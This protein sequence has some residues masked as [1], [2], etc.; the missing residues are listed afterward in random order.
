MR[1]FDHA[2]LVKAARL[3]YAQPHRGYHNQKHLD[4]LMALARRQ[5][6]CRL[7]V[8]VSGGP[9]RRADAPEADEVCGGVDAK[10]ADGARRLHQI[11]GGAARP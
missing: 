2:P 3:H 8:A 9:L 11:I 5:K 7:V 4:E 10:T 6:G 1:L